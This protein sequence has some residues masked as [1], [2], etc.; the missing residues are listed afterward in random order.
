MSVWVP[1]GIVCAVVFCLVPPATS[2][3]IALL[4]RDRLTDPAVERRFGFLY[5]RYRPDRYWW[6]GVLQLQELTLVAVEVF[7]RALET[8]QQALLMLV[9]FIAI[10]VMNAAFAPLRT[11]LMGLLEF[12]SLGVLSL[13]VTLSLY[14]VVSADLKVAAADAIGAIIVAINVG[15]FVGFVVLII[16]KSVPKLKKKLMRLIPKL[17][18]GGDDGGSPA[19]GNAS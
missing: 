4:H 8:S 15:L 2:F 6:E 11:H 3:T 16:R 1:V 13:T 18:R 12:I 7:A 5:K 14:F 19:G 10:G 9:A 17:Q